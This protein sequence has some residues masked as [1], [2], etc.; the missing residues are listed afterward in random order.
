M[1][2]N[3]HAVMAFAMIGMTLGAFLPMLWGDNETLGIASIACSMAGGFLGVWMAI[4]VG[5]RIG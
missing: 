4:I 1:N 3:K 5:R 2:M